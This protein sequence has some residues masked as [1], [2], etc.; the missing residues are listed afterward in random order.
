[1][2]FDFEATVPNIGYWIVKGTVEAENEQDAKYKI[3]NEDFENAI[4]EVEDDV[5][6]DRDGYISVN[7]IE[8]LEED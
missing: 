7:W 4:W 5:N 6:Q 1:M 2:K 8:E 3:E